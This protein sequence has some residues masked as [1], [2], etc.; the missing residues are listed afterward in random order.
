MIVNQLTKDCLKIKRAGR[1]I[2]K[3]ESICKQNEAGIILGLTL[4]IGAISLAVFVAFKSTMP[5]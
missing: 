5:L 3:R 2:I 4:A 1:W